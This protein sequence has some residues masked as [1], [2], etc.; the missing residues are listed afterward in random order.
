MRLMSSSP[1]E[2]GRPDRSEASDGAPSGGPSSDQRSQGLGRRA[3]GL[4]D[5]ARGVPE[6][7]ESAAPSA[8]LGRG[9]E[10]TQSWPPGSSCQGEKREG[11]GGRRC[12]HPR[13]RG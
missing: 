9:E 7:W 11:R 6:G 13:G 3:E 12:P 8:V 4:G 10:E 2:L 5:G 1:G